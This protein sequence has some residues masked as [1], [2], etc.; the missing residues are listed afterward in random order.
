M[1]GFTLLELL[2]VIAILAL[3]MLTVPPMLNRGVGSELQSAVRELATGLRWARTEAVGEHRS[4]ALWVDT[5]QKFFAIERREGVYRL[6]EASKVL[7]TAASSEID[8]QRAA[9]RF[10][11]DGSSTGGMI[12][13]G[14]DGVNYQIKVDWLTGG[15]RV[16]REGAL[17]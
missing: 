14:G 11:P 5:Q 3:A 4:V 7:V 12:E 8:G 10:F 17:P 13:V 1:R 9:V 6:P 2:V 16:E 15:V